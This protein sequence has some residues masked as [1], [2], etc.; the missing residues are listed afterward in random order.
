MSLALLSNLLLMGPQTISCFH[1]LYRFD[2]RPSRGFSWARKLEI[3]CLFQVEEALKE[4]GKKSEHDSRGITWIWSH[5]QLFCSLCIVAVLT[6][7][8]AGGSCLFDLMKLFLLLLVPV[9]PV[10]ETCWLQ[11]LC[12]PSI[13]SIDRCSPHHCGPGCKA[14]V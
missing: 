10:F 12:S 13:T 6:N 14:I 7:R 4:G 1:L 8:T 2:L 9:A 5:F 11:A 3:Y